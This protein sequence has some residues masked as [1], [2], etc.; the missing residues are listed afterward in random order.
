M[1]GLPKSD[2]ATR[3]RS[4]GVSSDFKEWK[5]VHII[6]EWQ[7]D[8]NTRVILVVILLPSG[9]ECSDF[10]WRVKFSNDVLE[11]TIKWPKIVSDVN[12]LHTTFDT[13]DPSFHMRQIIL[14]G[15][16]PSQPTF[17]SSQWI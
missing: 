13:M 8:I 1:E 4:Y 16:T 10:S 6:S 11:A 2:V 17:R 5:P 9:I 3:V 12:H 15:E 7:R 14:H